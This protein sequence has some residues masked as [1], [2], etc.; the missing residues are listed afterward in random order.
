MLSNH[1][2][3]WKKL[4]SKCEINNEITIS[5]V[6]NPFCLKCY[7]KSWKLFQLPNAMVLLTCMMLLWS[8]V[9]RNVQDSVLQQ[10]T[11][12]CVCSFFNGINPDQH[13]GCIVS[14]WNKCSW[15]VLCVDF[16]SRYKCIN[17]LFWDENEHLQII[18]L[19]VILEDSYHT[20]FFFRQ[21]SIQKLL[22]MLNNPWVLVFCNS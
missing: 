9:L 12:Q 5:V 18:L 21:V 7:I 14:C 13:Y 17:I 4:M 6:L 8:E 3:W 20:A 19:F 10:T 22:K 11:L 1:F 16:S 2:K 15:G